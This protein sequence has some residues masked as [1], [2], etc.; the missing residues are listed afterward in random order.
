MHTYLTVGTLVQ[1][2]TTRTILHDAVLHVVD[3]RLAAILPALPASLPADASVIDARS[4]IAIP[5]FVQTHIHLCQTLFRGHAED[6]PLLDWLQ[7]KIFP[8]EAAH[9]EQ[10]MYLSAMLGIAEL[11]RSGTTTI[12]DMGSIHHEEAVIRAVGESGFRAHVGKAMMDINDLFP[13]LREGTKEAFTSAR[14]LAERWHGTFD[15]RVHYAVAPRFVLS[16]T[17]R[18]LRDAGELCA[19]TPGMIFHTH[20]SENTA[21]VEAVRK[22]TGM[23]NI[24]F[25]HSL[26]VLS[27]RSCLAHCIHVHHHEVELLRSSRSSVTHCPSSNLKLA[28][29]IANVPYL[30]ARGITVGLGADG[31]PCNNT[32]SA[33]R[34][35]HLA[36]VLHKPSHDSTAMPAEEVFR[37]ATIDGAKALGLDR[38]IGSLEAGK[39]ADIVL[40]DLD[41]PAQPILERGTDDHLLYS[42]IVHTATPECVDSVMVDGKWL[43]RKGGY[44]GIDAPAVRSAARTELRNLLHRM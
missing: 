31:A 20:A 39:K 16:C 4:L 38:E 41:Q 25:L 18:L 26:G 44:T 9:D 5:G 32:L 27:E 3:D 13:G 2:G 40:L 11:I 21:E 30:R 42:A 15:G 7:S 34:E 37:M 14:A 1:G 17:D 29:G 43:Y 23:E 36:S 12:L 28:S 35:M 33:F 10:S 19:A 8:F 6:L 22:R 24:E